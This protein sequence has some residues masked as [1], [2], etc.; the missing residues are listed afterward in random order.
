MIRGKNGFTLIELLAVVIIVAILVSIAS[1]SYRR[2]RELAMDE[3]AKAALRLIK[4]AQKIY[5][6]KH[7][8]YHPAQFF[9]P[10]SE[11]QINATFNLSLKLGNWH[12]E[13]DVYPAYGMAIRNNSSS[14]P[15]TLVIRD[16]M[17]NGEPYCIT[18]C[19]Y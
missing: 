8:E 6:T 7:G 2:A 12:Y 17:Y 11:D 18:N 19:Y 1:V 14:T 4:Q 3:E 5:F 16:D 10:G 9:G 15:R 13:T